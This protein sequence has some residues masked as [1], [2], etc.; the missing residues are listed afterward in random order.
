MPKTP[1]QA[2]YLQQRGRTWYFRFKLPTRI[3]SVAERTE[4][5][6]SLDTCELSAARERVAMLLPYVHSFKRLARQ[7]S[8]LTPAH[9]Q[10]ALDL[11]FTDVVEELERSKAPWLRPSAPIGTYP[12]MNAGPCI[13]DCLPSP[14]AKYDLHARTIKNAIRRKDYMQGAS[15]AERYLSQLD[16]EA[17]AD[18]ER[19][20]ALCLDLLKLKAMHLE[21][22]KARANGDYQAEKEFIAYYTRAGYSILSSTEGSADPGPTISEAWERYFAEKTA[23]RPQPDWSAETAQG[24]QAT[25]DEFRDIV[26]DLPVRQVTRDVVLDY[27]EKVGRLPKNRTMSYPGKS[28]PEL[29]SLDIPESERPSPRTVAE[30]LIRVGAFFRWCRETQDYMDAD[31]TE[32]IKIRS[33]SRSYVPFTEHD[34]GLLFYSQEYR[35][36]SHRSL[37]QF[38]IPLVALYTGARQS[39]IAQLMVGDIVQEDGIWLFSIT[40]LGEDQKIKTS[41]D[42]P[43]RQRRTICAAISCIWS[44]PASPISC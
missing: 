2:S 21:A 17:D 38:W 26:G 19:F 12:G 18:S 23:G 39:E 30:K 5:R 22:K 32:G 6:V 20:R 37:W 34:L 42:R 15:L 16:C 11:Y 27:L 13:S 3:Q 36:N 8:K 25:F 7:M 28:I 31:P 4:I 35:H 43:I 10:K 24:Q 29:L 33:E 9:V 40:D 44:R 1:R 41:A 14:H